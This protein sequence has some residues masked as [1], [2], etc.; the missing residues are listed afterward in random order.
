MKI[1]ELL[2]VNHS[3]VSLTPEK[4]E[5]IKLTGKIEGHKMYPKISDRVNK[6]YENQTWFSNF[7]IQ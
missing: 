4:R 7:Q 3:I 2:N 5:E 6:D 1:G